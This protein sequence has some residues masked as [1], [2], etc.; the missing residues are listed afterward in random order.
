MMGDL[1]SRRA[2]SG[3]GQ[4]SKA[5]HTEIG[6]LV[7]SLWP[8]SGGPQATKG[9]LCPYCP[10]SLRTEVFS[11]AHQLALALCHETNSPDHQ[12][13]TRAWEYSR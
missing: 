12:T 8:Q 9:K 3:E 7:C 1:S 2:L 13:A 10:A 6:I 11:L 5:S 4:V